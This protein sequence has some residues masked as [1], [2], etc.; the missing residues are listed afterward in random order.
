MLCYKDITFCE[1]DCV[2]TE[3]FRHKSKV[4]HEETRRRKIAVC[5][6]DF[7]KECEDYLPD[8]YS[9]GESWHDL[10]FIGLKNWI[11][12]AVKAGYDKAYTEVNW[13]YYND[14]E[15]IFIV[16]ERGKQ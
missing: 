4:D 13:G 8:R 15:D 6:S 16:L 12:K 1:S 11:E 3:C 10:D 14:I 9:I 2:N 5:Y 7:S